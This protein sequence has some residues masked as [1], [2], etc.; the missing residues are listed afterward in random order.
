MI[1]MWFN[2]YCEVADEKSQ[3]CLLLTFFQCSLIT[4]RPRS[5]KLKAMSYRIVREHQ[6]KFCAASQQILVISHQV[7]LVYL[8]CSQR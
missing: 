5:T 2:V 4:L 6:L 3:Q 7:Q 1:F 8:S